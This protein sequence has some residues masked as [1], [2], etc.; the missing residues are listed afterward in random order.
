[1]PRCYKRQRIDRVA[2]N[3]PIEFFEPSALLRLAQL[4]MR[5]G[6]KRSAKQMQ[7]QRRRDLHG[8]I[9]LGITRPGAIFPRPNAPR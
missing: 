1:M 4:L 2:Q 6:T 5:S 9:D 8:V 7:I 3:N